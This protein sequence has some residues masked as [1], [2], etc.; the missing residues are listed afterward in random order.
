MQNSRI[1]TDINRIRAEGSL[2]VS[3]TGWVMI[4]MTNKLAGYIKKF[5]ISISVPMI[6]FVLLLIL[7]GGTINGSSLAMWLQLAISPAI[8]AWG[9]CFSVKVGMWDFSVGGVI[10]LSAIIGGNLAK[11]TG[12]EVLGV[13]MFC[14]LVGAC[15]GTVTGLLFRYLKIPSIIISVGM[16]L[17]YESIT[18]FVFGG[19]GV[20]LSNKV[21]VIYAFPYNV[22]I[23]LAAFCLIYILYN[24]TKF[25]YHVRAVGNS[26]SAAKM[27]G[28][29]IDR[30]R[31]GC[32]TAGGVFAGLYGAMMLGSSGVVVPIAD[33]SS[34]SMVFEGVICVFIALALE[35]QC[36]L[37]AGVFIGAITVQIIKGGIL[38]LGL[39]TMYQQC[40]VAMFLL[41]F[42][43]VD[44]RGQ[45]FIRH[46]TFRQR[47]KA[48]E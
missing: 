32:F 40:I 26:I 6:L 17:V 44:S 1:L 8:L 45:E 20:Q 24:Y 27:A 41:V 19:S 47:K 18:Q 10:Y 23:G 31:V 38:A 28:L 34:M 21:F 16:C 46:L 33:M 12:Q 7:C 36:N 25:G 13:I 37:I 3:R 2:P 48:A 14:P 15:L 29:E 5:L 43:S 22:L 35:R 11:I 39:P 9:V 4:I 42:M 30:V